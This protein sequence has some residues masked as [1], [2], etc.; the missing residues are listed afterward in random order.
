[1]P[2][3]T[4]VVVSVY[5]SVVMVGDYVQT[6]TRQFYEIAVM[7]PLVS[8]VSFIMASI[9]QVFAYATAILCVMFMFRYTGRASLLVLLGITPLLG[10]MTWF[11]YDRLLPDFRWYTDDSPPYEHGL[12]VERFLKAW[13]FEVLVVLLYWW[14][15]RNYRIPSDAVARV[16]AK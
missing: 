11:G 13:G 4:L 15:I 5:C 10:L 7:V 9:A 6:P 3:A 2:V 1:M 16:L 12:T 14:P 8:I